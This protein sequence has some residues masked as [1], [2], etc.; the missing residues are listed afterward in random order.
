MSYN[1]DPQEDFEE[2]QLSRA[3]PN[4]PALRPTPNNNSDQFLYFT[5]PNAMVQLTEV[6]DEHFQEGQPGPEENDEDYTDTGTSRAHSKISIF[7]HTSHLHVVFRS[8]LNHCRN[9]CRIPLFSC[10]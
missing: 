9:I 7:F 3:P 2:F 8:D 1:L 5:L 4:T 10:R 6:V